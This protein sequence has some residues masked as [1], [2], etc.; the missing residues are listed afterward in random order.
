VTVG[1]PVV[2]PEYLVVGM[3]KNDNTRAAITAPSGFGDIL[4]VHHRHHHQYL[5]VPAY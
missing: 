5:T 2:V 1:E 4:F 3:D